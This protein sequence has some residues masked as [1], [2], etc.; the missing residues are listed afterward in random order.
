MGCNSQITADE[1]EKKMV[2]DVVAKIELIWSP[3]F[4]TFDDIIAT[5]ELL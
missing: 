1:S 3:Y 2:Y 4:M 5:G